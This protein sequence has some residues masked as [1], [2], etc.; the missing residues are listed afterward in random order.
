MTDNRMSDKAYDRAIR[1]IEAVTI[2]GVIAAFVAVAVMIWTNII[3]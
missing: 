3:P 1:I 2:A